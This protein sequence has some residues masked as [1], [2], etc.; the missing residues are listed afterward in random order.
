MPI[1]TQF[2]AILGGTRFPLSLEHVEGP[3]DLLAS[4]VAVE[5]E[6][7]AR[8]FLGHRWVKDRLYVD[9]VLE[10]GVR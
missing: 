4:V 1:D 2:V 3:V 10:Q 9:I 7:Q 5:E 8:A 6:A